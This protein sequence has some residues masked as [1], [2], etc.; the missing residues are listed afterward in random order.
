MI[1]CSKLS[2][3]LARSCFHEETTHVGGFHARTTPYDATPTVRFLLWLAFR[4]DET[5]KTLMTLELTKEQR[6]K[7]HVSEHLPEDDSQN[8]RGSL[9]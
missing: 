2:S 8:K 1:D 5:G 7:V 9:F 3:F 6:S 4:N